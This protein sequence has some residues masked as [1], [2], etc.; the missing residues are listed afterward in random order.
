M[1]KKSVILIT[2]FI[3]FITGLFES[4]QLLAQKTQTP[5]QATIEITPLAAGTSIFL[6]DN[7]LEILLIENPALPMVGVN[8]IVKVGS[9]YETFATSG[10]SHMLEHLLFNGTT[11]REQKQLYDD[12]DRIGGYNNA[13]TGEYYTNYMMVT[14]AGQIKK[15]ME[16]QADML[17]NSILP[18]EK[19]EKEKGI[20]LE[21][22]AKS[23]ANPTEQLDRNI[24]SILYQGHALSLPTLGTYST[25][26][27]MSRN[28][29]ND[30]Y[31]NNYV[32][33]N[34][35]LSAVGNFDS[36]EMLEQIKEIYGKA[37]PGNVERQ[38]SEE[39][40]TGFEIPVSIN[41][42]D[43]NV[44][45]RFYNG[46]ET[47]LQNFYQMPREFSAEFFEFLDTEL[48]KQID[49]VQAKLTAQFSDQVK[50]VNFNNL[51]SPL[52]KFIQV[53]V[54][55]NSENQI[56]R[57]QQELTKILTELN[58]SINNE[59]VLSEMV[60]TR[61]EFLKNIEK[62]HMF[63]IFNAQEFA[64]KGI[65]AVL[66]SYSGDRYLK[67]AKQ[68]NKF[69]FSNNPDYVIIQNPAVKKD[70]ASKQQKISAKLFESVNGE[71]DLIVVQNKANNILA[72]HYLIKH[73]AQLE[74][75]FGKDAAK[76]LHDCFEQRMETD[77]NKKAGGKFGFSFTVND[78]PYIPMDNIYLHNDFGYIR[79]EGLGDDVKDA[80]NFLNSSMLKFMPTKEEFEKARNKFS[81]SVHMMGRDK[82]KEI[83]DETYK[84]LVYEKDK[85][86]QTQ[87][88]LTF[89]N[90]LEFTKEYFV[91]SNMIISV[92]SPES[93]ETIS[94][95]FKNF[96][97]TTTAV[98]KEPV[99]DTGLV[100]PAEPVN[101]EKAGGGEQSYLFWGFVKNVD[102][103]DK[104]ALQALSLV[105]ADRIIFDIREKQGMAY[106]MSAGIEMKKDKALFYINLPTR[107][108]NVDKIIPQFPGFFNS[109]N[110][111]SVT[112]VELEKS[113]NMYLGRMMFRRLSSINRGYYLGH[114]LYF[115][116]DINYD[117]DFLEALKKVTVDDAIDN[118]VISD[119]SYLCQESHT[120]EYFP[121][122]S[123]CYLTTKFR[124]VKGSISEVNHIYPFEDNQYKGEIVIYIDS[125]VVASGVNAIIGAIAHDVAHR[126]GW[127][128]AGY[129]L[130]SDRKADN[131]VIERSLCP[132][133]L[134][135][136][137]PWRS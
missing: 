61:T 100:L 79:A 86:E 78:N 73:K 41:K 14:P 120:N 131:I 42:N 97:S 93:A 90:L 91:P 113:V 128:G 104:P 13:N 33:N 99:Y 2:L 26:Q 132:Y 84:P 101:I 34:M 69:K 94:G 21:E 129:P 115:H 57:I 130:I 76:I 103:E 107:P 64:E 38:K 45:Y 98:S 54:I 56:G 95:M 6:L 63:G 9:A 116:G 23:L 49:A 30:F 52:Y 31:K 124:H 55:L 70:E 87:P 50:S 44:F 58:I 77:E 117:T 108:Q 82:A 119:A 39:M 43:I 47:K 3:V 29:V 65:Q 25:I 68:I 18:A 24:R 74:A 4:H 102:S 111:D 1:I 112:E 135:A 126:V 80:I 88:E 109:K 60:K 5:I 28:E 51:Q 85:F 27:N 48:K 66:A 136:K 7:G 35:I 59:F 17:F 122:F 110:I 71:A 114:S 67:A 32:P 46:E 123:S 10:M 11:T 118:M 36:A 127:K 81:R 37:K 16:I 83:F 92:G 62:P 12:V 133:L 96:I 22:I 72:V 121:E 134:E 20:V 105:L 75:K 125:S 137:K 40:K 15:G 8:V 106:R 89:K 19:F 53:D